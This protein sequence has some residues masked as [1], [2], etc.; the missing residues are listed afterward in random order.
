MEKATL[1]IEIPEYCGEC[2]LMDDDCAGEYCN[3]HNDDYIDITDTM[4]GKSDWCQLREIKE[5]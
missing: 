1:I 2:P 3:A 5:N 4:G